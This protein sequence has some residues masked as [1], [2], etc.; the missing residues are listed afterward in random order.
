MSSKE[1][2]PVEVRAVEEEAGDG[3][4]PGYEGSVDVL[5]AP[6]RLKEDMSEVSSKTLKKD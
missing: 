4:V 2:I 1:G 3:R 6:F 5:T